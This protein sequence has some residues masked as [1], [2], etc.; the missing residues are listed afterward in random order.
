VSGVYIWEFVTTL[1]YEWRVFRGRL[2]YRWT[3]W[4]Y[5]FARVTAL[6]STIHS[7]VSM[8]VTTPINCQL[9]VLFA[10]IFL[11]MSSTAASLLIVIRTIAIWNRN[12]VVIAMAMA[13]W[14][15]SIGFHIYNITKVHFAWLPVQQTCGPVK[16]DSGVLGF[17][18]TISADMALFLII[19]AGLFVLRRQ[20]G[21]TFGL[22]RLIWRQGV[23]WLV[24]GS[25]A[26]VPPI[27]FTLSKLNDPLH[28]L[29][30]NPSLI[31][32]VIAA[33][34][35]HR[36]L[37]EYASGSTEVTRE[38]RPMSSLVF[39][40]TKRTEKAPTALE[41]NE[42]S[43]HSTS[44][45]HRTRSK[46]DDDDSSTVISASERIQIGADLPKLDFTQASPHPVQ[47]VSI[48]PSQ[49]V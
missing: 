21:G 34:R 29:F 32:M 46:N 24:L 14:G 7:F 27:I 13:V 28:T 12:K 47:I 9:W 8:D 6:L 5:S 49:S 36:S 19:L 37:V 2:P 11:C 33:T 45:Q 43:M 16:F 17:I 44:N 23:M 4:I 22:S 25:A 18:P 1:D 35:M 42:I 38:G 3:M 31:V 20:G 40:K 30:A 26:E 48:S 15:T 10:V 41:R 39:S